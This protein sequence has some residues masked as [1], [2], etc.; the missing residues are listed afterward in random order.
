MRQLRHWPLW[1]IISMRLLTFQT[2]KSVMKD[3]DKVC[4]LSDLGQHRETINV[5]DRIGLRSDR[6][7]N[8]DGRSESDREWKKWDRS[9]SRI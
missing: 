7:G 4:Y 9:I 2:R 3:E 6:I 5:L 8:C 1:I